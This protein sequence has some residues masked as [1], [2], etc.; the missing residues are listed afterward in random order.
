MWGTLAR[1][2]LGR[3]PRPANCRQIGAGGEAALMLRRCSQLMLFAVIKRTVRRRECGSRW[4]RI[5]FNGRI[6]ADPE[7]IHFADKS[8][9]RS[10]ST[11]AFKYGV[12]GADALIVG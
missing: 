6:V 3:T 7:V 11:I 12:T 2:R 5:R 1:T 4:L 10:R 9:F 8:A